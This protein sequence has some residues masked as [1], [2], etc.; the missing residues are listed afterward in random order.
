MKILLL[1]DSLGAGGAERS[2]LDLYY[3]L[4]REKHE[5][6]IICI[7]EEAGFQKE[8]MDNGADVMFLRS[9]GLWDQ[10]SELAGLTEAFK[11]QIV[12]ATLFKSR[13]RSRLVKLLHRKKFQLVESLVTLSFSKE[14]LSG[15]NHSKLR[16][17][18][19][20]LYDSLLARLSRSHFVAISEEVKKH[21]VENMFFLPGRR[22]SVIYRGRAANTSI[23]NKPELRS[24]Y[25]KEFGYHVDSF[26][27]VHVGRQDIPKN[28][29]FLLEC[30]STFQGR[31]DQ[32][33]KSVLLCLGREGEMTRELHKFMETRGSR[34]IFFPGHRRDV[35][36][37][38]A[39]SDVFLFPSKFEGL[40]GSV[41]EAKAAALPLIVSDL[42][43][44]HETL[45][46]DNEAF[47][48]STESSGQWVEKMGTL[49]SDSKLRADMGERNLRTFGL[50]FSLEAI[51]RQTVDL[52]KQLLDEDTSARH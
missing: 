2:T 49:M 44:F 5:V 51:N 8:A 47:F 45:E 52:Y 36:Q 3:Y 30:F 24:A 38:L 31:Y 22:V 20:R 29:L 1:I 41:I 14:R 18:L 39:Q 10:V 48:V 26:V 50:K 4:T 40:G 32:A 37:L 42:S 33:G 43:V 34:N 21:V 28:H 9:K 27:F 35:P 16:V 25:A 23:R 46:E 15:R 17:L 11:P 6:K 12:H 19:H 7:R 13:L